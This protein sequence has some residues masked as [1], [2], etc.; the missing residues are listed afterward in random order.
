MTATSLPAPQPNPETQAFWDATARGEFLL[1]HCEA[2][3]RAHWYPRALCPHC[4]SDKTTWRRASGDA[5]LYSFSIMRR[6]A[7][8]YAIAYVTLAEGPTMLTSIVE[9]RFEEL[10]VGQ[11]LRVAFAQAENGFAV[12]VFKPC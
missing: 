7:E 3:E 2:C 4:G 9:C 10:H 12:P 6:V 8:P 1:R 11:R 5:T